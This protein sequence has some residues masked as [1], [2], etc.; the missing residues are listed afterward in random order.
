M[1]LDDSN[2]PAIYPLPNY[3]LSVRQPWAWLILRG[4]NF[5][6]RQWS[7]DNPALQFVRRNAPIRV[8]IHAAKGMTRADYDEALRVVE[9]VN[10][11]LHEANLAQIELPPM[12]QLARG[13]LIGTV[14]ITGWSSAIMRAN[15]WSFTSGL[16]LSNPEPIPFTPCKG[17][18]GFFRP[19]L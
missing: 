7:V 17:S 1:H 11:D 14:T 12:G 16:I 6:N 4:K 9:H 5:E 2:R 15:P 18:L 10:E 3:A 19:K 8:Y 13:G